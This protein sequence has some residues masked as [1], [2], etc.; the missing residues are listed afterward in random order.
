MGKTPQTVRPAALAMPKTPAMPSNRSLGIA[1][2]KTPGILLRSHNA[3][4]C[5]RLLVCHHQHVLGF[6]DGGDVTLCT[7]DSRVP[8]PRKRSLTKAFEEEN[9]SASIL[10]SRETSAYCG[11]KNTWDGTSE[12]RAGFGGGQKAKTPGMPPRSH[13]ALQC[14][15]HLVCHHQTCPQALRMVVT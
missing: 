14:Q 15:R 1:Q 9:G 4:Q 7:K 8:P 13:N 5:Q 3:L 10:T 6:A 2:P 12:W 11:T